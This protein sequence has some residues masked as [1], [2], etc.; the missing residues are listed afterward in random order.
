MTTYREL[1]G[2][3][4]KTVTT[5]PS[6]DAAEGQ[7]W[8]NSTDNTFKSVVSLEATS[9]GANLSTARAMCAGGGIQT[10][11]W[12]C[13]GSTGAPTVGT[14]HTENYDGNGWTTQGNLSNARAHFGATGV[15]TAGLAVSGGPPFSPSPGGA[16]NNVEHYDGEAWTG[17]GAIPT[18]VWSNGC[19]G[20]QTAAVSVG[21]EPNTTSYVF[22]YNGS[23]WTTGGT[24]NSVRS[25]V[26]TAGTLTAGIIFGGVNPMTKTE[27]YDGTSFTAVP[28]VNTGSYSLF[29]GGTQTA[30]IKAGGIRTGGAGVT[31]VIEK[32]DG[33]TWSTSPATLATARG[34]SKGQSLNSPSNTAALFAGGTTNPSGPASQAVSSTEEFNISANVITAAAFSSIPSLNSA[35]WVA[36][37]AGTKAAGIVFGGRNPPIGQDLALSEE[38]NGTSWSEGP[39]LGQARRVMGRGTGTS[40]AALAHGG[41]YSSPSTRYKVAEE[42]NGS[43][44]ANGG[45]STNAHDGTMQIGT[46]TAA[47]SCGGYD[48][49]NINKTESYNGTSFS[50]AED[51]T[52]SAYVGGGSGPQTAAVV[53]GGGFPSVTNS[54][55]YDGTNWTA[56]NTLLTVTSGFA[57]NGGGGAQTAAIG[58]GGY[59]APGGGT[60][61][62]KS[63]VFTYDGTVFS[64]A[65]S[66]GSARYSSAGQGSNSSFFIAGGIAPSG[67]ATGASEEFTAE[68]TAIN[69]K[70]LT[71]S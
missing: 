8:F 53:Y 50:T 40:T 20:I 42:W 21:S 22:E 18:N 65:P 10:A 1:H 48:G 68:T 38:F 23:S 58:A 49:T 17:G 29:S 37:A 32:Y 36:G 47:A 4:I 59:G 5:N 63:A 28:E 13:G 19:F 27:T 11:S 70:T 69:V 67:S 7:I 57:A 64:T 39:D 61:S 12:L 56:G 60:P 15:Q 41:H 44:W 25:Y 55:E 3:A 51:M 45:T 66:L 14:T 62:Y 30:A 43:T 46:Q 2:K 26:G 34:Y 35:R 71:Q 52:Y 9:N 16:Q 33:S 24:L 6:D 54:N 31:D